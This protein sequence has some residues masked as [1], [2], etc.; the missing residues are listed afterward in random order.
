MSIHTED[1]AIDGKV[2]ALAS[3][4]R[5][6]LSLPIH[7]TAGPVDSHMADFAQKR[8]R[9]GALLYRAG[10]LNLDVKIDQDAK[11]ALKG[12]YQNNI[13]EHLK[14][15]AAM[16]NLHKLL[17][18]NG[19]PCLFVKGIQLGEQLSSEP[20]L[21]VSHDIDVV[22]PPAHS[23]K[24]LSVLTKA[25]YEFP[26]GPASIRPLRDRWKMWVNK[27]ISFW[28]PKLDVLIELHQ[29]LLYLEPRG[30]T[31]NALNFDGTSITPSISNSAYVLYIILHGAL[32]YF[33]RLKW[34]VDLSLL[35]RRISPSQKSELIGLAKQFNCLQTLIASLQFTEE[36]FPDSLDQEWFQLIEDN[37]TVFQTQGMREKFRHRLCGAKAGDEMVV[38]T[39][40][41]F[42]VRE[43]TIFERGTISYAEII[44][45]RL[46]GVIT[47]RR[48]R[49]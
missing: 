5:G 7:E 15:K 28:D 37:E 16:K 3:H 23:A 44:F 38:P 12:I 40:N 46:C 29:R 33:P 35:V 17:S 2:K 10:Q 13:Q 20:H 1:F 27:D 19:V 45:R 21:R 14:Q 42:P 43:R 8:H 49:Y 11:H 26:Y 47:R 4:L 18:Q 30:F 9:V 6:A 25:G 48:W 22:V 24:A 32:Q 36:F 41:Y 34:L 31:K 39:G